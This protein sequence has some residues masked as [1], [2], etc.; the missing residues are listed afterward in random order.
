MIAA[1]RLRG[2]QAGSA[3]GAASLIADRRFAE[4]LSTAK[5]V[6]AGADPGRAVLLRGG[7][8]FYTGAI[9][10][11]ARRVGA[12]FSV[13]VSMNSAVRHA[14][15]RV[16]EAGL[17]QDPLPETRSSTMTPDGGS[18]MPGPALPRLLHRHRPGHRRR[19]PDPPPRTRHTTARP[20]R[21]DPPTAARLTDRPRHDHHPDGSNGP[22]P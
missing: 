19:G 7:S 8:A 22:S 10:S 5:A 16:D 20:A 4:A 12:R 14:I 9:I 13:T 18:L 6:G 15:A 1:T 3:R 11:A 21:Q 17:D 2:G